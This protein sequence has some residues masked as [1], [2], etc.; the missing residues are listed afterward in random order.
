MPLLVANVIA[1]KSVRLAPANASR[2]R[3]YSSG[4]GSP[5]DCAGV[6]ERFAAVGVSERSKRRAGE[7]WWAGPPA[8]VAE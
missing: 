4:N 7:R 6:R 1:A 3:G 2:T 5:G 8:G